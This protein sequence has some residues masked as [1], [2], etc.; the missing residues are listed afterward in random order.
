M[1]RRHPSAA[2]LPADLLPALRDAATELTGVLGLRSAPELRAGPL[3]ARPMLVGAF[4]PAILLPVA[5]L[6][7]PLLAVAIRPILAHELAHI[8]RRD[9]LWSGL[10]GSVRAMFFFHPLVWV[11][12]HEALMARETACDVLALRMSNIRSSEHGR[13]VL[14]IAVGGPKWLSDWASTVG[15]AGSTGSLKRRLLAMK[16]T[17]QPSRRRLMSWAVALLVVGA[18]G[19][20]PWQLVPREALAQNPL[21]VAPAKEPVREGKDDRAANKV[22][23]VEAYLQVAEA[24][25]K[26]AQ[27][28]RDVADAL[29]GQAKAQAE[30]AVANREYRKKQLLRHGQLAQR[31]AV[32]RKLVDE[33]QDRYASAQAAAQSAEASVAVARGAQEGAR[34]TAREAE[35]TRDVAR[36]ELR[37]SRGSDAEAEKDLKTARTR[38]R[39]ARLDHARSEQKASRAEIDRAEADMGKARSTVKFR[40]K[41]F[42]R[43]KQLRQDKQIEQRLVDE[44]EQSLTEARNAEREAEAVVGLARARMKAAEARLKFAEVAAAAA[45]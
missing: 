43:L 44:E 39:E 32:E 40:T 33:E 2:V 7:D 29:V 9:L 45:K 5:L 8:Y 19:I 42:E 3:V 24:R 38:V 31:K 1:A 14:D 11:A 12:H 16:M 23:E 21:R 13:I 30:Q 36:A 20:I 35:A 34:A 37:I 6:R 10:A 28:E 17:Q 18:V 15:T 25:L 26:V 27:A 41:V 4:R 22:A